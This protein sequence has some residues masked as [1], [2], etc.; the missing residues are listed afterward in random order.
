M[1]HSLL[2]KILTI[3][4]FGDNLHRIMLNRGPVETMS[5]G[6]PNDGTP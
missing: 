3:P 4:A 6:F 2:M 5:E 1:L